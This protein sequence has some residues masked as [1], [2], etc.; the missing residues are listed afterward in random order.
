VDRLVLRDEAGYPYVPAKTLVGVWRDACEQVA[1][2][3]DEGKVGDWAAYVRVLFGDQPGLKDYIVRGMPPLPAR[4]QVRPARLP[5]ALREVLQARPQ[6]AASL[7]FVKASV[8]ID[9]RTGQALDDHLRFEELA[10]G[11]LLLESKA[12]LSL[13]ESWQEEQR[14][15][16]W[17]LLL[18][19]TRFVERLGG[20][21]RRGAGRCSLTV[22]GMPEDGLEPWIAWVEGVEEVAKAPQG[23]VAEPEPA[24]L[25]SEPSSGP[26]A[27]PS[28][29][30]GWRRLGLR[31]RC[32]TPLVVPWRTVGNVVESADHVPGTLLLGPVSRALQRAS[33]LD[34]RPG[35]GSGEFQMLNAT[36]EVVGQRGLPVPFALFHGKLAGGLERG[37]GVINRLVEPEPEGERDPLKG[38]RAGWVAE[39]AAEQQPLALPHFATIPLGLHTHNSVQDD[40]QR[41]TEQTGGVYSYQALPAGT[42][43]CGEL[44]LSASLA[45]TLR[46]ALP[47]WWQH[48]PKE[49]R[50]GRSKKDD[51]GQV[52]LSVMD[53]EPQE[54]PAGGAGAG[55][56]GATTLTVWLL[57]DLLLRDSRLR[58]TARPEQLAEQLAA[59]H[60]GGLVL[61]P[62]RSPGLLGQVALQRRRDSWHEG[63]G[64]PRPSLGG[65]AGG[66]CFVFEVTAG[67]L[68]AARLAALE[69][70]GL[71]ERRAE[72]YGQVRLQPTWLAQPLA[73]ALAAAEGAKV[74]AGDDRAAEPPDVAG[75]GNP[76]APLH[77]NQV[78]PELYELARDLEQSALAVAVQR[79]TARLAATAEGRAKVLGLAGD[80]PSASQ[81]GA[82]R[83]RLAALRPLE[84]RAK[85]GD[86]ALAL[87][88]ERTIAPIRA[89]LEHL[90]QVP[91]RQEKWPAGALDK[92]RRLLTERGRLW[93]VLG[94]TD[95]ELEAGRITRAKLEGRK[96]RLWVE[97][98]G[99]LVEACLRAHK[100]ER[101]RP[102]REL[103]ARAEQP[104]AQEG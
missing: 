16:A 104:F 47:S 23:P 98:V 28:A 45:S 15:A 8:K 103:P 87:A 1:W 44:R 42:V 2:G 92:V 53:L 33:G 39:P 40:V 36:P 26:G 80:K 46:Q 77:K 56:S 86:Q 12:V 94:L 9:P 25:A 51:Y 76:A 34:L 30:G 90:E 63:W 10:R 52:E 41:P 74:G 91:N 21:R 65:L 13:P 59:A 72:G 95:A 68:D 69:A 38:Y 93:E 99:F 7:T 100:R 75:P 29:P 64:L 102:L 61:Q 32:L 57:S 22:A 27:E 3:L 71:G 82:L 78:S 48:L 17:A 35:I 81:L 58:P 4:L 97:A 18:L 79:A 88:H 73:G 24:A 14:R 6:V 49:L 37:R 66:S 60:G 83:E 55:V 20:K 54:V 96:A 31:L 84:I 85:D 19:G 62:R 50:L 67:K 70:A 89:W 101:E 11:G 5:L 43:L